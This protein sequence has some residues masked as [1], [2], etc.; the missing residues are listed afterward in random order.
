LG[1]A[2]RFL[3]SAKDSIRSL[4]PMARAWLLDGPPSAH[5]DAFQALTQPPHRRDTVPPRRA[6][7]GRPWPGDRHAGASAGHGGPVAAVQV[8]GQGHRHRR[9]A[10]LA[11]STWWSAATSTSLG[12]MPCIRRAPSSPAAPHRPRSTNDGLG[13]GAFRGL[14][15]SSKVRAP[16]AVWTRSIL[17]TSATVG[18]A[19][20]VDRLLRSAGPR[21][22]RHRYLPGGLAGLVG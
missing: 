11:R 5:V 3:M 18:K 20:L 22:P 13:A 4:H 21:W 1:A 2:R 17:R 9:V 12:S 19:L 16:P 6:H 15:L 14:L 8:C 10:R 7:A